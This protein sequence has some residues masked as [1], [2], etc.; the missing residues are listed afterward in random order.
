LAGAVVLELQTDYVP[1]VETYPINIGNSLP[2]TLANNIT[3]RPNSGVVVPIA[4]TSDGTNFANAGVF[5]FNGGK[6]VSLDGRPGGTGTSQMISVT[7]T[8]NGPAVRFINEAQNDTIRRVVLQ[9]NNPLATTGVVFFSTAIASGTGNNSNG[10]D[11]CNINANGINPYGIISGGSSG[12]ANEQNRLNTISNCNIYD[13]FSDV[14]S[15]GANV[16]IFLSTGSSAFTITGNSI[17]QTADR[18]FTNNIN[19]HRGILINSIA[20]NSGNFLITNNFIGGQAPSCGG[21]SMKYLTASSV[22]SAATNSFF[23]MQ[24]AQTA[25]VGNTTSIQGNTIQNLRVDGIPA[26]AGSYIFVGIICTAGDINAGTVTGNT[27]GSGTGT[28][29]ITVNNNNSRFSAAVAGFDLRGLNTNLQNN[30]IGS[31]TVSGTSTSAV[32][33]QGISI[34]SGVTGT[35]TISGN[36]IGSGTATFGSGTANSINFTSANMPVQFTAIS[37]AAIPATA[38]LA[39]PIT[40]NIIAN[41]T[42]SSTHHTSF[43]RGILHSTGSISPAVITGN[44]VRNFSNANTFPFAD[45]SLNQTIGI[46]INAASAVGHVVTNNQIHSLSNTNAASSTGVVGIFFNGTTGY[47]LISRNFIHSLSASGSQSSIRG[48]HNFGGNATIQNNMIRLGINPDGTNQTTDLDIQAVRTTSTAAVNLLNNSIYVGGTGV[49]GA[50]NSFA[51]YRVGANTLQDSIFNNILVNERSNGSGTG[52]HFAAVFPAARTATNI[53][54]NYNIYRASGTGGALINTGNTFTT[55]LTFSQ[56]QQSMATF[57]DLNS[58]V[59]TGADIIFTSAKTGRADGTGTNVSLALA[60]PS[61]ANG[62]GV[63]VSAMTEDFNGAANR[64]GVNGQAT[65]IGASNTATSITASEDIFAPVITYPIPIKVQ[66]FRELPMRIDLVFT[67]A[68]F[69]LQALGRVCQQVL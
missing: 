31:I 53:I 4:F 65:N 69:L 43:V 21:V 23:G 57:T 67:I 13:F 60:N 10:L 66:E 17:Y 26:S 24:I 42:S 37:N 49:S 15:V 32:S 56:Y 12:T 8:G 51:Y 1:T 22:I 6:F 34:G 64:T 35:L 47:N 20:N 18:T 68:M 44:I 14:S 25:T 39:T 46:S 48:I 30:T 50:L 36:T 2:T 9:S 16:G 5:D 38:T 55:S 19:G 61:A 3:I 27:I 58:G 52:I 54:S 45:N 11:F 62:T 63:V 40:N 28:A 59:S 33:A 41:I 7:N 29:S